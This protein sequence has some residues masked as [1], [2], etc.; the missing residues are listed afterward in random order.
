MQHHIARAFLGDGDAIKCG[1]RHLDAAQKAGSK[2][3]F[4]WY[5]SFFCE[6]YYLHGEYE[7]SL[8]MIEKTLEH[9][10]LKGTHIHTPE[11]YR[12]KGLSLKAIGESSSVVEEYL[13]Q[14][15]ELARQQSAKTFELR[16]ASDLAQL[17]QQQGKVQE[18]YE[19]LKSVYDW[20]TEGFDAID[21]KEARALLTEL[22][23]GG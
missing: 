7:S 1:I 13:N 10:N 11:L 9:V 5:S 19:L 4:S 6:L 16:A 3:L 15:I 12:I 2:I 22:E 14:A 18:A 8:Q 17:W 23:I 20:F 21:L